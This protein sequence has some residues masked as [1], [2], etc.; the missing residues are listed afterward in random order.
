MVYYT[1]GYYDTAIE[2]YNRAIEIFP[3][4]AVALNNK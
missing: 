2:N 3:D 4:F 1:L